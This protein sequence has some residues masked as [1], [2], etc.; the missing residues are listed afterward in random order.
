MAVLRDLSDHPRDRSTVDRSQRF[1]KTDLHPAL[2]SALQL[3][4]SASLSAAAR[5]I[6]E[7]TATAAAALVQRVDRKICIPLRLLR[8]VVLEGRIA[9]ARALSVDGRRPR[10]FFGEALPAWRL[11]PQCGRLGHLP[12]F[13][14]PTGQTE[15]HDGLGEEREKTSMAIR[16]AL[17]G[18]PREEPLRALIRRR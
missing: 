2:G 14:G 16:A 11:R 17:L 15:D 3:T 12:A 13:V 10:R 4:G 1:V 9:G 7:A 8:A 6:H 5:P 18:T